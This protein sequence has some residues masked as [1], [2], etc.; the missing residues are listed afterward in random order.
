LNISHS[1]NELTF[2]FSAL[3]F[4]NPEKIKYAYRL[5][6]FNDTW[7]QTSSANR[8]A[9]YTNLNEGDYVFEVRASKNDGSWASETATLSFTVK[10]PLWRTTWAYLFYFGVVVFLLLTFRRYSLI[11]VKQKNHLIIESIEHKKDRELN[12]AKMRFFTNISHEIRTPLTLIH[13]P[14]QQ[15]LKRTD[16]G[17]DVRSSLS[18]MHRN[19]KRLL[20]MVNQLLEF[21]KMDSGHLQ[22]EPTRFDLEELCH[23]TLFAF[24]SLAEQKNIKTKVRS[25]GSVWVVADEKMVTTAI[26][27]LLSN[28]FKYTPTGGVVTVFLGK[29]GREMDWKSS[30][31]GVVNICDSGPGIPQAERD[32]VFQRFTQVGSR[33]QEH[34]AGSGIGLSIVKEFV[35]LNGGKVNVYNRDMGGCCFEIRLPV[36]SV[37]TSANKTKTEKPMGN[38]KVEEETEVPGDDY[39]PQPN[40]KEDAS[41]TRQKPVLA[42][43]EDD[44]ELADWLK[45]VFREDF[46]TYVFHDGKIADSEISALTPDLIICDVMLPGMSGIDLCRK[47]KGQVETSH[48]PVIMLTARSGEDNILQGLSEGADSYMTKPFNIDILKAQVGSLLRSREAFRNNFSQVMALEPSEETITPV[49]EKF[50]NRL[51]EITEKRMGDSAFDVSMLVDEMHMSHSLILKKVK[52]LSGLSLVEFIRSMRI[53]KAA[54][55]FKQDR[56]SVSEVSY[57]VGFSD[58]KYF[59]KCFSRQMGQKPTDFIKSYHES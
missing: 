36:A 58:P 11:G 57:M 42:V 8:R 17:S 50:L 2:E 38:F 43:V 30:G 51:M 44:A 46:S 10:P 19:V 23:D 4:S 59:S 1:N 47:I 49:D 53:K 15:V 18:V 52:A 29:D 55:I 6:G 35:E 31:E 25:E 12:E 39:F 54:Q 16:I 14:L 20:N 5:K 3:H 37:S 41:S 33:E 56:L 22:P 48:I 13:A 21:R 40:A 32:R 7:Q 26:Y 9:T 45:N 34:L 28:A 24:N 27:N